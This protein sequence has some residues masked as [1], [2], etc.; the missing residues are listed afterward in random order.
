MQVIDHHFEVVQ[1]IHL[2]CCGI[3]YFVVFRPL[4]LQLTPVNES[5]LLDNLDIFH[6]N[7]F[8]FT[9]DLNG[10]CLACTCFKGFDR[11][12]GHG[13]VVD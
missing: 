6:R 9:V 8:E 2:S 4:D 13:K 11:W 10:K 5:I 1:E 7:G 3:T 12:N